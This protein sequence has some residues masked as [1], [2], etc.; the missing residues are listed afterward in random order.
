MKI[1]LG[2]SE[3]PLHAAD[4]IHQSGENRV[5]GKQFII[6]HHDEMI[7]S[8]GHGNIEFPVDDGSVIVLEHRVGKEVELVGF[9][10]GEA[11]DDVFSL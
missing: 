6:S 1:V 9:L 11:I 2:Y 3:E 8:S 4:K 10:Y 5:M 7:L